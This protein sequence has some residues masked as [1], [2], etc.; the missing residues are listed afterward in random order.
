MNEA[1]IVL[2]RC[3]ESHKTIGIR[4]EQAG[5]DRWQMTWAFPIKEDTASREGYD[6]VRISGT[7][8]A[9]KDF[10]GCPHCGTKNFL[11]CSSCGEV[12]CNVTNTGSTTCPWCGA[13][14]MIGGDGRVSFSTCGDR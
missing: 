11:L 4:T 7:V 3:P 2:C 1:V 12:Y 13:Q 10:N 5:K 14:G 9:T 8:G 6:S